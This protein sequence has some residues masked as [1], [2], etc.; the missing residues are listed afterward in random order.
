M[1]ISY[2]FHIHSCLSPCGNDE[3]TPQNIVNMAKMLEL[4]AIA[5]TDHNT[6]LNCAAVMKAGSK[7]GL[8][9]VPGM[10]LCTSEE[11]HLV[12]LFPSLSSAM[13][14]S[15]Y[16]ESHSPAV[17]NRPDIFGRQ[18][19]MDEN[20]CET[21]EYDR[22]LISASGISASKAPQA[23]MAHGGICFPAH[24]DRSAYSIISNLGTITQAMGFR[25]AE[26]SDAGN[27]EKLGSEYPALRDMMIM[28]SSDAHNLETMCRDSQVLDVHEMTVEGI[29]KRLR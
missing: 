26:V 16:V 18:I 2:D 17:R 10:E 23:V 24:I 14:F 3:M 21:G 1:N 5:L 28:R 27:P 6:C 15:R 20:D 8:V 25:V 29:I 13:A 19:I 22:L 9:V 4:D 7:V 12:C 11:V